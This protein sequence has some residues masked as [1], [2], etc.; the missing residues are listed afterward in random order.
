[1][2][3]RSL[4][5]AVAV[6]NLTAGVA[7]GATVESNGTDTITIVAGAGEVNTVTVTAAGTT[8]T[9]ADS[10]TNPVD[11][12]SACTQATA[13]TVECVVTGLT[14]VSV[15]LDDLGDTLTTSALL[16]SI[17]TVADLGAGTDSATTGAGDDQIAPGPGVD[18]LNGGTGDDT[19]DY[20]SSAT[21]VTVDLG[22]DTGTGEGDD[23]LTSIE[24]AIG[25]AEGDTLTGDAGSN[26]LDGRDG[27]DTID[28]LGGDDVVIAG[29]GT[30]T[31]TGGTHTTG[32]LIDY[33][34][35][36]G[37]VTVNLTAGT[38]SGDG[39]DTVAT[40]E[41]VVGSSSADTLTGNGDDNF[42][43]GLQGDDTLRG[44]AGADTFLGSSGS[45]TVSYALEPAAT[46]SLDGLTPGG[47]TSDGTD[48]FYDGGTPG[49]IENLTGSAFADS[50]T[51]DASV[52]VLRG[53]AGNDSLFGLGGDDDLL[54]GDD[55]D[56]LDGGT[57]TDNL[58]G[59]AGSDTVSY[60]ASATRVIV[61]LTDETGIE[62]D[63]VTTDTLPGIENVTGS[64]VD[65]NDHI[66][67][68]TGPNV[69][70]GGAGGDT[71]LAGGGADTLDGGTGND[72][73]HGDA[74]ND[75]VHA[76]DPGEDSG[77]DGGADVDLLSF[78]GAPAGVTA[79][80]EDGFENLTGSSFTDSLTGDGGPNVIDGGPGD[81]DFITGGEGND[82]L[83]GGAG[84]LDRVNYQGGAA[85]TVNLAAGTASGQ[86]S[87][88]LAGF[89]RAYGSGNDDVLIGDAGPNELDGVAG[90]DTFHGGGGID[91]L[92]GGNGTD[93]VSY[94]TAAAGV[95]VAFTSAASGEATTDGDGA[96]DSFNTMENIT[97]SAFADDLSGIA[98]SAPNALSGLAGA[99]V[100]RARD[101]SI[102]AIDCGAD[103]D[104]AF[105]D[106]TD[107]P[108]TACETVDDP[109]PTATPAITGSSPA[110]GADDNAPRI[111][112]T[113]PA[114]S[115]VS[116]YTAAD[117]TGTAAASGTAAEFASPGLAVSVPDNSTTTY[118][119]RATSSDIDGNSACSAGY[120]HVEAT[121]AVVPPGGDPPIL[122]P[123]LVAPE[124]TIVNPKRTTTDRTPTFRFRSSEAGATFECRLDKGRWQTC[125]SPRT[126][127]RLKY[128][129]HTLRVRAT[130][131]AG[132]VDQTPAADTFVVKRKKKRG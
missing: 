108:I 36:P 29:G 95:V 117:C 69:I 59:E 96:T 86:G 3:I 19:V 48:V 97:G 42:L 77:L 39:A 7:S 44:M 21:A 43:N 53:L 104:V 25:S 75:T 125:R 5:L 116:L 122:T 124:T 62:V 87:D 28:A 93:T 114:G 14:F 90:N 57:G 38:G 99:D 10:G 100:I 49:E 121:P 123:D 127:K 72:L 105:V 46:A 98:S 109:N 89:E 78:A 11:N 126:L 47:S 31:V 71:I 56:T 51:G 54:G 94:A 23:T 76:T 22:A 60:A 2:K 24:S 132:N 82:T 129:K 18:S 13:S 101:T 1:V 84:T 88:T 32:D 58:D 67:G 65:A 81:S 34:G 83:I 8:Y 110:S 45:D 26:R 79:F 107:T 9:I 74:G 52:N 64:D 85:V 131:A 41:H 6:L 35:A 73:V 20:S 30:D 68:D 66:T 40:I 115:A 103:V 70:N 119:A 128:G 92:S 91:T 111:V 50:L 55:A 80:V 61:N 120:S 106:A 15:L 118:Y 4:L 33:S 12:S 113:A 112:G 102:D 130:D 16:A 37:A 27:N 63:A 17:S